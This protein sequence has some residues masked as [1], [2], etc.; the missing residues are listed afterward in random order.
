MWRSREG[1][2][3]EYAAGRWGEA[4]YD[5]RVRASWLWNIPRGFLM[6][7]ADIVPGVS[8]GTIAL[9][10]NIYP[11]LVGSIRAG[12]KALG[13]LLKGDVRGFRTWLGRVEWSF[14]VPLLGGIL[15][16]VFT[17]AHLLE[18]A[19]EQHPVP[20]AALFF[21]LVAASV[22]VAWR[23]LTVRNLA[24]LAIAVL[25]G[26]AFFLLLG[27][28]SGNGEVT[29]QDAAPPLWAFFASGAVAICAMIL[30]GISGSFILVM[31]GMYGALLSAVADL[32]LLTVAVF[33]LGAVLGLAVFSQVLHWALEH[34]YNPVIAALVGL[35][36]GSFRVL[37]PWPD[38][39]DSVALEA[40]D[41]QIAISVLLAAAGFVLVLLITWASERVQ[42]IEAEDEV[43]EL[44][45]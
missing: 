30:P 39:V 23:L 5:A 22:I 33:A 6:G 26:V 24:Y 1:A 28:G 45:A 11:R 38:G 14:L 31:L 20:M 10:L 35:L 17:L 29:G 37:W 16:A 15:A 42:H 41:S 25:V 3:G 18:S 27:L 44:K 32:D 2:F 4:A 13:S 21:G 34:H 12:S 19:L 9:V 43:R 7:S 8:G 36:L 40:P